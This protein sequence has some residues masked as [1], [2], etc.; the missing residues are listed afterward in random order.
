M[1]SYVRPGKLF[2]ANDSLI[3]GQVGILNTEA[4]KQVI[5]SVIDILRVG[6]NP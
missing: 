4:L 1:V 2:T 5:E 3:V 6:I